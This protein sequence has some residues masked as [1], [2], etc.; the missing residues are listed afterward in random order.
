M[1]YA[2]WRSRFQNSAYV[3]NGILAVT[4]LVFIER[5]FRVAAL[6]MLFWWHMGR[7]PIR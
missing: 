4:I 1:N 6:T 7:G 3:T 2:N 5:H